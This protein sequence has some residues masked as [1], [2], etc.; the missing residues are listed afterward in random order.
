M[1]KVL[2]GVLHELGGERLGGRHA[3]GRLDHRLDRFAHLGVGHTED[4]HVGD[5][6]MGDEGVL[7]GLGIDVHPA[8]DDHEGLAVGEVEIAVR[9]QVADVPQGV[10]A[11]M[12]RMAGGPGLLGVVVVLEGR[13]F[14]FEVDEARL[15]GR[16]VVPLL[17]ADMQDAHRRPA[18][19]AGVLQPVRTVDEGRAR[20]FGARI[21]LVEN[22]PPPVDHLALDLHRAGRGGVDGDPQAGD[23]EG[24]A[25]L[26]RQLEHAHEHGG[27]PLGMGDP[28][29]LDQFEGPFGVEALHHHHRP[30]EGL[31]GD[32]VGQ[33]GGVV[34]GRR[35]QVDGV[36][37]EF[38]A[39]CLLSQGEGLGGAHLRQ[40]AQY[41]LGTA[42]GAR[43]VEH[44]VAHPLPVQGGRRGAVAGGLVGFPARDDA[45]DHQA[46]RTGGDQVGQ[47]LGDLALGEG[48]DQDL[49]A[50]VI[51]DVGRLVRRQVAV[52]GG[53][54]EARAEAGPDRIHEGE[55]VFHQEGH[56]VAALQAPIT[57]QVGHP[58][59]AFVELGEGHDP[60]GVCRDQGRLVRGQARVVGEI[61]LAR[62]SSVGGAVGPLA[63]TLAEGQEA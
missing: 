43:A 42:R 7:D 2:T 44:G 21:V 23:V 5:L 38:V 19:R 11:G 61:H 26:F 6:G 45:I 46:D 60:A 22:R 27:H 25:G 13:D 34:E 48:A 3:G 24:P 10:P 30:A 54:V 39:V 28:V 52:D 55:V 4:R 47:A 59:G 33:G 8:R 50:A 49:R 35:R 12:Q 9:I 14:A 62:V 18:H 51:D 56:V 17:I 63:R 29:V 1:G 20:P 53:D 31:H 41:A 40:G 36:G 37:A 32:H 58:K 15:T 16:Q 57:E